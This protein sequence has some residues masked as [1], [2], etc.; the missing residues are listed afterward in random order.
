MI[1]LNVLGLHG[2]SG[3]GGRELTSLPAQPKRFAVLAYLALGDG[4][5]HRRDTLAAVFWPELDQFAARRALR[6]TLYHLRE[7]LGEGV[8]VTQG[9]DAVSIDPARLTCDATRLRD[10]VADGRYEEAVDLYRGEL[11]PGIHPANAGETFE[12]WL[13]EERRRVSE[14]VRRAV[15][16]LVERETSIGNLPSAAHWAQRACAL[17]PTDESWLRRAMSLL[18]D[19][20][21]VGTALRLYETFVRRVAADFDATPSVETQALA[22][23]IRARTLKSSIRS[24]P[25]PTDTPL[26]P[27]A[28]AQRPR[29]WRPMLSVLGI[30][31]A[32]AV[33]TVVARLAHSPAVAARPRVLVTVFENRTGDSAL[34]SLGRMTQDWLAQGIVRARLIDVVDPRAVFV[35]TRGTSVAPVDPVALAHRTG[36]TLIVSGSYDR[37]GDTLLI[38]ASVMD[39]ATGRIVRAVGPII[40]R[41]GEPV[42]ALDEVRSRV[43]TAL[44]SAVDSHAAQAFEAGEIPTYDA[45]QAYVEGWDAFWHGDGARAKALFQQAAHRDTGFTAAALALAMA[46][47]NSVGCGLV[48]SLTRVLHARTPRLNRVDELSLQIAVAHCHGRNEETLRLTLERADLEPGNSADEMSAA[49]AASLANRPARTLELLERIDPTVDLE[50][51]TDS[52]HSAYWSGVAAALEAL[53]RYRE[54][55]AAAD[56]LLPGA[57]L[58]R[59]WVRGSALA[60]LSRPAEVLALLDSA[61]ALP[62][63]TSSDLGLAPYTDGRPQYTVTPAWVANWVSRELAYRGDTVAAR[64]AAMR[65]MAWYRSRRSDERNT[66]EERLVAAWSLE[67]IGAYREAERIARQ[68]VAEDSANVDFR[69]ELAG[70]AAECGDTALADSLDRWLAAQPVAR[71]SWSASI[72]RARVAALLGRDD[73]AVARTREAFDEGLWPGWLHQEPALVPLRA[74]ADFVALIKPR[75]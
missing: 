26:L 36:A 60:A 9:D 28:G 70:L 5:H 58:T 24:D 59:V 31:G 64:Q 42:T 45:Y 19:I 71:V 61:L 22:A 63:E 30:A 74:R 29:H 16:A 4:G 50:W 12:E 17:D 20:S 2:L 46:G 21:D 18:D 48:D 67:M 11:L 40:A 52:T 32:I 41:A 35:Q 44:A 49:A 73:S 10:A 25:V 53:G 3:P 39:V 27:S 55:L 51:S 62:V 37:A 34:R 68:L 23:R 57:P 75:G 69:G 66:I 15:R 13:S 33:G 6:N 65:A 14:L 8:I 72:Y 43:M 38:Q 7:A 47:S 1:E 56:H 54:E